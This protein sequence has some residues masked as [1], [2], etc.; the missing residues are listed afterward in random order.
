MA[1]DGG[2]F[3][4]ASTLLE[5]A[6]VEEPVSIANALGAANV[7]DLL[8]LEREDLASVGLKPVQCRRVLRLLADLRTDVDA[9]S[10]VEESLPA[11]PQAAI[12]WQ[13]HAQPLTCPSNDAQPVA[14]KQRRLYVDGPAESV[15]IEVSSVDCVAVVQAARDYVERKKVDIVRARAAYENKAAGGWTWLANC[16]CKTGCRLGAGTKFRFNGVRVADTFRL[17]VGVS[18][19]CVGDLTPLRRTKGRPP[20]LRRDRRQVRAAVAALSLQGLRP[21]PILVQTRLQTQMQPKSLRGVLR[22]YRPQGFVARRLRGRFVKSRG[23]KR[24]NFEPVARTQDL[25]EFVEARINPDQGC[26]CFTQRI[27]TPK[28]HSFVMLLPPFFQFFANLRATDVEIQ[29]FV[30]GGDGTECMEWQGYCFVEIFF[31][32][33]RKILGRWRKSALPAAVVV[34]PRE[35]KASYG[36]GIGDCN[37]ELMRRK[38]PPIYQMHLDWFPGL[39]KVFSDSNSKGVMSNGIWHMVKICAATRRGGERMARRTCPPMIN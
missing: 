2:R 29:G 9:G 36:A 12:A 38:L 16:A 39:G 22:K 25:M 13:G 4:A 28:I 26:L 11:A 33:Y 24:K 27:S 7:G 10:V 19:A 23:H 20:A 30:A 15:N 35:D 8:E 37:R 32:F 1:A 17:V 5:R 21:T 3:L 34:H 14:K 6:G 31:Q 18:G